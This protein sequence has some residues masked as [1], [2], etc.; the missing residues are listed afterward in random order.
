M[1]MKGL[2]RSKMMMSLANW[3]TSSAVSSSLMKCLDAVLYLWKMC[4]ATRSRRPR[5][6]SGVVV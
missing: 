5:S 1:S 4:R 6:E 2:L 3:G